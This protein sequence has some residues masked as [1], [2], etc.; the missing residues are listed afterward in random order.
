MLRTL[1][2]FLFAF[3]LVVNNSCGFPPY[4]APKSVEGGLI[5]SSTTRTYSVLPYMVSKIAITEIKFFYD[6]LDKIGGIVPKILGASQSDKYGIC[7]LYYENVFKMDLKTYLNTNSIKAAFLKTLNA[8]TKVDFKKMITLSE[9]AFGYNPST[10]TFLFIDLERLIMPDVMY[11]A[12]N[13][14]EY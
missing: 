1:I 7:Y 10:Q 2:A 3:G 11:L 4:E 13:L 5:S 8:L 14:E 9:D 6:H 12:D